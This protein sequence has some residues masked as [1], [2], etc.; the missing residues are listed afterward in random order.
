MSRSSLYRLF[1][2]D[3]GVAAYIQRARLKAAHAA[4]C[5]QDDKSTIHV[6]AE[7]VGFTDASSFSRS[8]RREFGCSPSDLRGHAA[9]LRQTSGAVAIEVLYDSQLGALLRRL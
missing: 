4:L 8:F 5:R 6:V 3:G 7:S 2:A 1:E 9:E